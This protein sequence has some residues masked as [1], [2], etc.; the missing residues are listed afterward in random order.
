MYPPKKLS[1]VTYITNG[2][3]LKGFDEGIGVFIT[4]SN[5]Q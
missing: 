2:A 3:G 1:I 4:M 5:I